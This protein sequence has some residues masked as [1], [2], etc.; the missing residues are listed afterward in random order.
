LS[1][2]VIWNSGTGSAS[3]LRAFLKQR[4]P[5]YMVP[6][7]FMA[8]EAF[9]MTPN[10]KLDRRALPVAERHQTDTPS[11]PVAPRTAVEETLLNIW[12]SVLGL[13]SFGIR[14]NFF[15]LGGHSLL[16]AQLVS[17]VRD[18]FHVALP[19]QTLFEM[20]SV[21]QMATLI[22]RGVT[23]A[24]GGPV[25]T[26]RPGATELP[27]FLV[28]GLGGGVWDYRELARLMK[29]DRP[30]YGLVAKGISGEEEPLTAIEDIAAH[31][32]DAMKSVQASGPY[33]IGGYCF[34]GVVAVEMARQLEMTGERVALLGVFEGY[35]PLKQ[36]RRFRIEYAL[37]FIR[38]LPFWF[39]ANVSGGRTV[40]FARLRRVM[41]L[42]SKLVARRAGIH[43]DIVLEDAL[44]NTTHVLPPQRRLM[45]S[46]I[47]AQLN[48]MPKACASRI[49][50]I[51]V[52]GQSLWWSH[53]PTLG[54]SALTSG[55]VVVRTVEGSHHTMLEPPHVCQIA[56]QLEAILENMSAGRL[57]P[58]GA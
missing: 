40:I 58:V 45:E 12:R 43:V 13:D 32:V 50:L 55:G 16:A 24:G 51:R 29:P 34:G 23:S 9:P 37:N 7:T 54:W 20:P 15:D 52:R 8:L 42:L 33:A 49:T 53:D 57:D 41:R 36:H 18:A 19:V 10:G 27:L 28:H 44:D 1:A 35:A 30:V 2:Y 3:D 47:Q 4:L 17:R 46:Q 22:E 11:A 26:L 25:V 6:S 14:D 39:S 21:E 48:F 31:C 5:D 38:N 56:E